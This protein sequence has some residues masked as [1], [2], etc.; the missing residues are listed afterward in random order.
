VIFNCVA[1]SVQL[2]AVQEASSFAAG[3]PP[4]DFASTP[5]QR[6][7]PRF[8][9]CCQ[10]IDRIS[11]D[12]IRTAAILLSSLQSIDLHEEGRVDQTRMGLVAHF[13]AQMYPQVG[14]NTKGWLDEL[15]QRYDALSQELAGLRKMPVMTPSVTVSE[16][17]R[18][19]SWLNPLPGDPTS[20][21][22]PRNELVAS[23]M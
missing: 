4:L 5:A 23:F 2:H 11:P 8:A 19:R 6:C 14:L 7:T 22:S 3:P 16:T 1:A 10:H 9:A 12:M 18:T 20:W 13:S 15:I 21:L 17:S